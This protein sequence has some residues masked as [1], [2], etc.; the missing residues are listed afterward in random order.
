MAP[1][2]EGSDD[3]NNRLTNIFRGSVSQILP[4]PKRS[5]RRVSVMLQEGGDDEPPETYSF[6]LGDPVQNE[7]TKQG[8]YR[9]KVGKFVNCGPIQFIMTLLIIG[10]AILL[11]VF[12]FEEVRNNYELMN[13]LEWLDLAFLIS[14][15]IEFCLQ[16]FYLGPTFLRHTWLIFDLVVITF[17][18]AFIDG[19]TGGLRSMRIFRVLSLV[20]KWKSLQDLVRAVGHTLPRLASIFICLLLIFYVYM[21]LCTTLYIDLYAEGY[22]NWPY[23]SRLDYTFITLFQFMTLDSWHGVIRQVQVARPF[24][25]VFILSFVRCPVCAMFYF[26]FAKYGRNITLTF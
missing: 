8:V 23:F 24:R 11:G 4:N 26:S 1:S 9:N 22:L 14:F 5:V 12:T 3:A 2:P 19:S 10:N 6:S 18:W 16:F 7:D 13:T 21:V 17:S 20:S 25:Y 15:T